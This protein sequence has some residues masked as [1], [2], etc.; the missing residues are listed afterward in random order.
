MDASKVLHRDAGDPKGALW[1]FSAN[2]IS[3]VPIQPAC[4]TEVS[5][6][7]KPK[8]WESSLAFGNT[9]SNPSLIYLSLQRLLGILLNSQDGS[10][11]RMRHVRELLPQRHRPDNALVLDVLPGEVSGHGGGFRDDSLP[12]LFGGFFGRFV[13]DA[14]GFS[15]AYTADFR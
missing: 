13:E 3:T 7:A 10:R 6:I 8:I 14:E 4:Q 5:T 11:G 15:L 1:Y 9:H 12:R 2:M